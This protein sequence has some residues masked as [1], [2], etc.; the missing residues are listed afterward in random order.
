MHQTRPILHLLLWGALGT[1]CPAQ[2]DLPDGATLLDRMQK[3]ERANWQVKKLDTVVRKGSLEFV[4]KVGPN[5]GQATGGTYTVYYKGKKY[6]MVTNFESFGEMKKG[7]DGEVVWEIDPMTGVGLPKGDH[8]AQ[9]LRT[10]GMARHEPWRTH[11][12]E[13]KCTGS[14][15]INGREH[16]VVELTPK[17]GDKETWYIDGKLDRISRLE[18]LLMVSGKKEKA[19][20][21]LSDF[22]PA[23]GFEQAHTK[24][25]TFGFVAITFHDESIEYN[26]PVPD[27][28]FALPK[29]VTSIPSSETVN[30][31]GAARPS[32]PPTVVP[33][34]P[35]STI[36]RVSWP[37]VKSV[38]R[39]VPASRA[40]FRSDI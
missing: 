14:T 33:E 34:N 19:K 39:V 9:K 26:V 1:A 11:Y 20:I 13:A 30:L 40:N 15:Q 17:Q 16:Y 23:M 29:I 25:L 12:K 37:G 5:P 6:Y 8:R 18:V 36:R 28:T 32:R 10:Y 21:E 4:L 31:N 24:I 38:I 22:R 7:Y 35:T 3:K 27:S 2:T